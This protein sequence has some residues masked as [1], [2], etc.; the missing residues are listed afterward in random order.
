MMAAMSAARL[1]TMITLAAILTMAGLVACGGDGGGAVT[2]DSGITG[3]VL[4]GPQCPVVMEGS[5]CPDKPLQATLRI[6]RANG[7]DGQMVETDGQGLFRVA[8]APGD[9][10]VKPQS[11]GDTGF[12]VPPGD[13]AV[14]VTES[15]FTE[16]TISYDTGIR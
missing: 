8:L 4:A 6:E 7:G 12:P 5:P 1:F 16:I 3:Q 11:V 15:R 10:V 14:S 13:Q 9:Y 2:G